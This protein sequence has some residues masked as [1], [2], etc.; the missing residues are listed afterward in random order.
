MKFLVAVYGCGHLCS[1]EKAIFKS[2]DPSRPC[3][4]GPFPGTL[5]CRCQDDSSYHEYCFSAKAQSCLV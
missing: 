5:Y 4:G 1:W 2:L 3:V